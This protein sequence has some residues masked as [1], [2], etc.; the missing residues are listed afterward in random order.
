MTAANPEFRPASSADLESVRQLLA[1]AELPFEDIDALA[2]PDFLVVFDENGTLVG[3][4]G[5][6]RYGR[7][8]LLRSVVVAGSA[9]GQG[10]GVAI[11]RA[12]EAH[13][14]ACGVETLYLLTTTAAAF[15]P[16][17]GYAPFDRAAVPVAVS[18]S[19]EFA[20]VCPASAT[21]LFKTL[22]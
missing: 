21:C 10:L 5:I 19:T 14:Q 12:L 16:R 17:L 9:R 2:M 8:G 11:V 15:F 13:A 7:S 22:R 20:S 6:E 3:A 18:K 4:G 1:E